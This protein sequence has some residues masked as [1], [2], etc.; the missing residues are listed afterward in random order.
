MWRDPVKA[1]EV[2]NFKRR[3]MAIISAKSTVDKA[4]GTNCTYT[5]RPDIP[6]SKV[7]KGRQGI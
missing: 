2:N 3:M 1:T 6:I 4:R 5:S 7:P